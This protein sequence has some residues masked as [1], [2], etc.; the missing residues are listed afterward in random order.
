MAKVLVT[1][2]AGFIGSH[3][4]DKLLASR[5]EA[6]V[7]DDLRAGK[8]ANLP[9]NVRC[10]QIDVLSDEFERVFASERPRYVCHLAAQISVSSSLRAPEHDAANNILGS[11]RV[12]ECCRKHDVERVVYASSAAVYGDPHYLPVDEA[13]PILPVSPY[14]ISKHAAEQYMH[15]YW[16]NHGLS[17]V[18]LRYANVYGPRQDAHGEAGVVSTFIHR[19]LRG[20][21]ATVDG[22]GEQTR[23]FLYVEDAATA[24]VAGLEAD[25][26]EVQPVFNISTSQEASIKRLFDTTKAL[27]GYTGSRAHGPARKGDIRRSVLGRQKAQI[28][29]H[30]EPTIVLDEGLS[31]TVLYF[32]GQVG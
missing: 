25:L 3:V 22:D 5:H 16:L 27:T 6:V 28:H 4:V 21:Q 11:I 9:D 12:L 29:L 14:G 32:R 26:K 1:G 30:W 2:G 31:R 23:D 7:V 24:T 10:Y 20:E 17:C 8:L 18:V 13:H 15:I 19:M